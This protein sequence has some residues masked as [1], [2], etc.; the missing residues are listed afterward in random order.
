MS[1]TFVA[2][3]KVAAFFDLDGTLVTPPSLEWRF[4]LHLA[5]K[6]KLHLSSVTKWL[7]IFLFESFK[8]L[9]APVLLP[10]RLAALDQNKAHLAGVAESAVAEWAKHHL[11]TVEFFPEALRQISWHRER[12]HA[13]YFLSGTLGP[14]ARAVALLLAPHFGE[15]LV[16]A[17]ELE[18]VGGR[19][20][21]GIIGDAICGPAKA[22]AMIRLGDRHNLDLTRSFAYGNSSTDRWMLAAAGHPVAINPGVALAQLA[23]QHGWPIARWSAD[24]SIRLR[25]SCARTGFDLGDSSTVCLIGEPFIPRRGIHGNNPI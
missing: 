1:E 23:R 16:S 19:L 20:T 11:E 15:I 25:P 24:R 3:K 21:G 8:Q 5:R 4:V 14:F 2:E 9:A 17:T 18:T 10:I 12:G 22:R 13:I 7:G 6:R